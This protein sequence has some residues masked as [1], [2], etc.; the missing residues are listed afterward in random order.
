MLLKGL[1]IILIIIIFSTI[2][3]CSGYMFCL[4]Y[5]QNELK[6]IIEIDD[7]KNLA[8]LFKRNEKILKEST[9]NDGIKQFILCNDNKSIES[10][11]PKSPLLN[12]N[13]KLDNK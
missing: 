3:F 7:N 8:D 6:K 13:D 10:Q 2:G 1:V 4:S 12:K 11:K 5:N 9:F